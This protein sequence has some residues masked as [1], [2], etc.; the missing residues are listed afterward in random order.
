MDAATQLPTTC[1]VALKEWAAVVEAI[2]RGEQLVLIRKGGLL[3]PGSGFELASSVFVFY[4]TFEHQTVRYLREPF[5][6]YLDEALA[7]RAPAGEVQVELA[8]LAVR[9]VRTHDPGLLDRLRP[10]HVYNEAFLSQ[11]LAWQPEVPLVIVVIRAVRLAAPCR[12]SASP[13]YAGCVSWVTLEE[14]IRLEGACP[15]QEE[16]IFRRREAELSRWLA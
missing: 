2:A 11:R 1:D 4:P 9:T 5:G 16:A 13:R 7:R 10:F 8:G 14:P 12:L 15:V 6:R 3:E